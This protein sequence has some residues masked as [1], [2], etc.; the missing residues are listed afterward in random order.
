MVRNDN[1]PEYYDTMFADGYEP[2]Q[3]YEAF[4]RTA[5]EQFQEQSDDYAVEVKVK[6]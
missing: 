5:R 3:I 4:H 1:L 2:W 6:E